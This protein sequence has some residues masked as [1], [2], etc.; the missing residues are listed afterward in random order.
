MNNKE[1]KSIPKDKDKDEESDIIDNAIKN[2]DTIFTV[3]D[4]QLFS[5]S[6][7]KKVENLTTD[8]CLL[9]LV[10]KKGYV[11]DFV[12]IL[13]GMETILDT[14]K[15]KFELSKT[16]SHPTMI[17]DFHST[18]RHEDE[19]LKRLNYTVASRASHIKEKLIRQRTKELTEEASVEKCNL[20][21]SVAV[22]KL[23][24]SSLIEIMKLSEKDVDDINKSVLSQAI[25]NQGAI[26]CIPVT[27]PKQK[28]KDYIKKP[29]MKIPDQNKTEAGRAKKKTETTRKALAVRKYKKLV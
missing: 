29:V 17:P 23:Y 18:D 3:D 21:M 11:E 8:I 13:T 10:E 7:N 27:I 14:P 22:L 28:K 4:C 9:S 12:P 1:V 24:A 15:L 25:E 5:A 16:D 20:K 2:T 26:D 19:I 6:N